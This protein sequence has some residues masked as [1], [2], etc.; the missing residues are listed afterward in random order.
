MLQNE[1]VSTESSS[2]ALID[3]ELGQSQPVEY[4]QSQVAYESGS[5]SVRLLHTPKTL[6]ELLR[7]ESY[8]RTLIRSFVFIQNTKPLSDKLVDTMIGVI[9]EIGDFRFYQ[10]HNVSA[11]NVFDEIEKSRHALEKPQVLVVE[12]TSVKEDINLFC[13]K[14]A[15]IRQQQQGVWIQGHIRCLDPRIIALFDALFTFDVSMDEYETLR[16]AIP[17]STNVIR[18]MRHSLNGI[19]RDRVLFFLNHKHSDEGPLLEKNPVVLSQIEEEPMDITPFIPIIVEATKFLFNE[20]SQWLAVVRKRTPPEN[21]VSETS[22][23]EGLMVLDKQQFS[24]LEGDWETLK[25]MLDRVAVET[26]VYRIQGLIE[27]LQ[28]HYKNLT[29]HEKTEAEYGT[30]V[31]QH[32]K[33]AI[34][35]ES[36]AIVNKTQELRD[37][38]SAVYQRKVKV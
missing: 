24:S 26:S 34:E 14:I 3:N 28:T 25:K 37:L 35:H 19:R 20:A 17:L 5:A 6:G 11:D 32:V 10:T 7:L 22:G 8:Y 4:A 1:L 30:L 16:T 18:E 21:N 13:E 9:G 15:I 31:P 29:D 36:E 2:V 33:R 38:L 23:A 27:Q 12:I